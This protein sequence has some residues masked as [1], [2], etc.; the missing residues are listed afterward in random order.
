MALS[1]VYKHALLALVL[2]GVILTCSTSVC[3]EAEA[4]TAAAAAAPCTSTIFI[5]PSVMAG[6]TSTLYASTF[7]ATKSVD[8]GGCDSLLTIGGHVLVKVSP[9]TYV[10]ATEAATT[11][12]MVCSKTKKTGGGD[13]GLHCEGGRCIFTHLHGG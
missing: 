1:T 13:R 9:L 11:T 3:A 12:E 10:S 8:C 2:V 4:A 7:T 5:Q 6:P